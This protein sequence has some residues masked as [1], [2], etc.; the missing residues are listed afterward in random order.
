MQP[1]AVG[2]SHRLSM[3]RSLRYWVG[4]RRVRLSDRLSERRLRR[5]SPSGTPRALAAGHFSFPGQGA[6]AGDLIAC[7]VVCGW[8]REVGLKYDVALAPPFE[9]GCD[10]REVEPSD[11]S[12]II[13]I[14]GPLGRETEVFSRLRRRFASPGHRWIGI[15]LSMTET[16]DAWNPFDALLERDSDRGERADLV[17][18]TEGE[19]LPVVGLVQVETF[20]PLFPRRDRQDDARAAIHRLAYARPAAVVEIET[21]LDESN[22]GG[23]RSPAEVETLIGRMDVVLTTRLHGLVLALKN[24]VPAVAVDPVVRGDKITAQARAVEWPCAFAVDDASDDELESA[25]RFALS[26][27]G[28][29]RARASAA[30]GWNSV[31][32]LRREFVQALDLKSPSESSER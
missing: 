17:F 24:G 5:E 23:L 13:W 19:S 10:W 2:R 21:R 1:P 26:E 27:E 6:T 16:V 4:S 25:L 20:A 7:D 14:C 8:L 9:G 29:M 11:Y 12:H 32:A 22:I 3:V 18:G 30:R 31:A 28:R 15:N